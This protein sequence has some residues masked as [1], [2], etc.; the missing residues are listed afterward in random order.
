M[1]LKECL[2]D[3]T[4]S[5]GAAATKAPDDYLK[6]SH[7]TYEAHKADLVNLW[8]EIRPQLRCDMDKVQ[9]ID[10]KLREMISAF[11]AGEKEKGRD[12]AWAIYNLKPERLR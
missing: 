2:A 5:I 6:S 1:A 9:F 8:T 3:F 12:A 7:W 4:G 10:D 11:D